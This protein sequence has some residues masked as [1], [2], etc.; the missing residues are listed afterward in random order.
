MKLCIASANLGGI[1]ISARLPPQVLPPGWEMEFKC[2]VDQDLPP[3]PLSISP[4]MQAKYPKMCAF[5]WFKDADLI[6][7]IDSSFTVTTSGLAAWLIE[8]LGDGDICLMPHIARNSVSEELAFMTQLMAAGD[9]YLVSRYAE[10]PM[11]EQV[12]SYLAEKH[13]EDHWLSA[14]GCFVYRNTPALQALMKDWLLECVRWSSQDQLSLPYVMQRHGISPRWLDCGLWNC[15]HMQFTGHTV[16]KN[17]QGRPESQDVAFQVVQVR[18]AGYVHAEALTEIAECVYFGLQRLGVKTFYRDPPDRPVR[19]IVLGAHLL[20]APALDALPADAIIYNSEQIDDDS[21]WLTSRY[22][23]ALKQRTVWDY[24]TEN[25]RRLTALGARSVQFVPV[26]YVPELARVPHVS[27]EID[28]LFY[29]S[30]NPRRQHILDQLKARGLNV[31]VLFGAYGE[32]RD[33]SIA[34]A[35]VVLIAHF[36]EAKIFEIVRAA[37]LLSNR[38]AVVA[39]CGPDTFVE[40]ELRDAMCAVP[41]ERLVDACVE[42]ARDPARRETLGDRAQRLFA[43]RREEDILATALQR[44]VPPQ[45]ALSGSTPPLPATLQLGSGKDFKPDCLN[46]DINPAWGPDAV[47]D[48]SSPTL[49]GSSLETARFGT[50]I[51]TENSFDSA[52]ANDVLEHIGDLTS[53]MTNILRLLRP[54]GIFNISVPYDMGLGAWQD[55]THVRAFNERSWLYYTDWHWYLGW[56]EARFDLLNLEVEMSPLGSE[57]QRAGKTMEEIIRV[58]RAVDAMRVRLQ[59]RYLQESERIEAARRQPG[60]QAVRA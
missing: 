43:L 2:F 37:Y 56:T 49:I 59:K 21:R 33:R 15:P 7:W 57:L 45:A 48:V 38:K 39:E 8:K 9:Q 54:G 41:Y 12:S 32:E 22:V 1:D 26:G 55:P 6:A 34:R 25:V 23:G 17:G 31:V 5:E 46:V 11:A 20:D 10:E 3:R 44:V 36:Y 4:R 35:K 28:V 42:L 40:P 27:D 13:F 18:P 29:G 47:F 14:N 50:V 60:R 53:A 16:S 19:Q 58:P 52:I 30:V 24:S 51:L